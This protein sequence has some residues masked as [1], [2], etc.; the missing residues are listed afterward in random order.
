MHR[1]QM[2]EGWRRKKKRWM[3]RRGKGRMERSRHEV[4]MVKACADF[5]V[6]TP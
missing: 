6:M 4:K 2:R 1:Q 5:D 3:R